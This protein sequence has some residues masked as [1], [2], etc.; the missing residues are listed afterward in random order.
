[1]TD[2]RIRTSFL[3]VCEVQIYKADSAAAAAAEPGV[4]CALRGP[5]SPASSVW[6]S[7]FPFVWKFQVL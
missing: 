1:M 4:H 6:V 7:S 3:K 5:S 2:T